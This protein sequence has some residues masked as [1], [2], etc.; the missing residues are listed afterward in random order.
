MNKQKNDFK[1]RSPFFPIIILAV[2]ALLVFTPALEIIVGL[3]GGV[4][5]LVVGLVAGIF[6]LVVGLIGGAIGI[7]FGIFGAIIGLTV[8]VLPLLV[9]AWVIMMIVRGA[10]GQRTV[11]V[12][13]Q[14]NDFV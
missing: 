10:Q 5:G 4:I 9:I 2:I 6:G 7:V 1:V 11:E 3:V 12:P 8:G 13:K 14:K